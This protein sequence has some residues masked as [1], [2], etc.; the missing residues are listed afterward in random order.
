[1]D[2]GFVVPG[3]LDGMA[4]FTVGDHYVLMRNSEQTPKDVGT[5][6]F[7]K[8]SAPRHAYDPVCMGAVTRVVVNRRTLTRISSNLVLAGTERNCAGGQSPWGWL[9]CEETSASAGSREGH[10]R[11]HGYVFLCDP[12]ADRLRQPQRIDGYGRF[13][14]EAVVVDPATAIAYF[15]E[16]QSDGCLYRFVPTEPQRPFHGQLQALAIDERPGLD[17]GDGGIFRETQSTTVP[18]H[19]I[20]LNADEIERPNLRALARARGAAIFRRGEGMWRDNNSV[21]FT[22]TAGGAAGRGQV[23]R[24]SPKTPAACELSLVVESTDADLLDHPDNITVAPWGDLY[25]AEDNY[26][27][28]ADHIRIIDA[29]GTITTL[30]RNAADSGEFAGLCW[31][32]DGT[33]LFANIYTS[34]IT[35]AIQ[36]PFRDLVRPIVDE[37]RS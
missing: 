28:G 3:H 5:G 6:P 21:V 10:T 31:A 16:D 35:L 8:G 20:E 24:L 7:A 14:H 36:G 22:A 18:C 9:S 26:S 30:A 11:D 37:R 13:H 15:T 23:F 32:P 4:C 12:N 27:L 1:M 25:V 17:T 2:D 34:G 19:W 29:T 33:T